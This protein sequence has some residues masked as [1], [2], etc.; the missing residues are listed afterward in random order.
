MKNKALLAIAFA[1]SL[2][3]NAPAAIA[4]DPVVKTDGVEK[5]IVQSSRIGSRGKAL[6]LLLMAADYLEGIDK[7]FVQQTYAHEI[8]R[9]PRGF[10]RGKRVSNENLANYLVLRAHISPSDARRKKS[11]ESKTTTAVSAENQLLANNAI[12][13]ALWQISGA[14]S[15]DNADLYFVASKLYQK[16]RND[17]GKLHCEKLVTE[18]LDRSETVE[19]PKE[20]DLYPGL[21]VLNTMAYSIVPIDVP[22]DFA[23]ENSSPIP[24]PLTGFT[25]SE[26]SESEKLHLRALAMTDKLDKTSQ[27][28]RM[29]HRN[30]ALWYQSL[31]RTKEF[32]HQKS[33]LFALIGVSDDQLLYA[34]HAGCCISWWVLKPDTMCDCGRG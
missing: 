14:D 5:N 28:R 20:A 1:G 13:S 17:E 26:I 23:E 12:E 24:T 34:Q 27:M 4:G 6:L 33:A 18:F 31:G 7:V 32:E 3:N 29:A 8:D 11:G 16:N 10:S 30:L 2:L 15:K 9:Y 22:P 21:M 19:K 25:Q